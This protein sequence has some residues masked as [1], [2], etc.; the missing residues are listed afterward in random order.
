M[1]PE[2]LGGR[3]KGGTKK[4]FAALLLKRQR[5][6]AARAE[7]KVGGGTEP[8]QSSPRRARGRTIVI[9]VPIPSRERTSNQPPWR[10]TIHLAMAR[11]RPVPP[12]WRARD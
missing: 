5:K 3:E 4:K 11:P 1:R 12:V 7:C 6:A 2:V 8:V 9:R 10:S